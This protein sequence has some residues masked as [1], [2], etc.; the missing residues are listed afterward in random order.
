MTREARDRYLPSEIE[1]KWQ[2][3]WEERGTNRFSRA[4][5]ESARSPY[6]NLMMFPYPSAEGLHA[7]NIYAFTPNYTKVSGA[8]NFRADIVITAMTSWPFFCSPRAIST[9]L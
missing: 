4:E 9:A 7:G 3:I 1:G 6:Y 8:M 5:L 2:A